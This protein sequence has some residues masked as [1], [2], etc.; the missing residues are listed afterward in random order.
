LLFLPVLLL[1]SCWTSS[2]IA[3]EKSPYLIYRGD[4][5]EMTVMWELPDSVESRIAWGD[6]PSCSLGGSVV[7]PD[8]RTGL[9]RYTIRGLAPD[10]RYYYQ[11]SSGDVLW[12]D[13][14]L[15]APA[16]DTGPVRLFAYGDSRTG[17]GTHDRLAGKILETH[18]ADPGLP[19]LALH[20]GDIVTDGNEASDWNEEL[21][22]SSRTNIRALMAAVPLEIARGNHEENG[23]FLGIYY[24]YSKDGAHYR[25]F[26]FGPVHVAVVDLYYLGD[27]GMSIERAWLSRDMGDTD[28]PWKIVLLHEPGWSASGGHANSRT[29]QSLF[30]PIFAAR[31][32]DLVLAG[33]NHYYARAVVD[34]IQYVT[35]GGGG[36]PLHTPDPDQAFVVSSSATHHFCII[37]ADD[38]SLT[39]S[40]R[41]LNGMEIDGF[42][43]SR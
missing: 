32:V 33:H 29:V 30:H 25:S 7:L 8:E 26:D 16:D 4:S 9:Y 19:A 38:T 2:P 20:T 35:T 28:R 43:L 1:A 13:S 5:A 14:F 23:G 36:A 12:S 34:G 3:S 11:V 22:D 42:T 41:D 37:Q 17:V 18:E 21:F 6:D 39:F 10:S 24:P 15:T 40:A 31:R 27:L